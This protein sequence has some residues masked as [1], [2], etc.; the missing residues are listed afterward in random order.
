M[1]AELQ[2]AALQVLVTWSH[3]NQR[4]TELLAR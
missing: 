1:Q 4:V 3:H 2:L